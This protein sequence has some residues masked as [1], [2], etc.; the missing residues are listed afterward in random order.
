MSRL[1][2][3]VVDDELPVRQ[4][5]QH[6]FASAG[7]DAKTYENGLS[8]LD[9]VQSNPPDCVVLDLYM[10]GLTGLDVLARTTSDPLAPPMIVITGNDLP[11]VREKVME[12]GAAAYLT[13]PIEAQLLIETVLG[14]VEQKRKKPTAPI[15]TVAKVVSREGI[16]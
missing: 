8:L 12:A 14:A 10:P 13:K 3:A 1:Q 15:Q 9:A 6:L 5:L 11:G 2:I 4:A 7:L 16:R